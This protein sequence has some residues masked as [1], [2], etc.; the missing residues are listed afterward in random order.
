MPDRERW[1]NYLPDGTGSGLRFA[2]AVQN[3]SQSRL[4]GKIYLPWGMGFHMLW[5][6][7]IQ[8]SGV[9]TYDFKKNYYNILF[10]LVLKILFLG[11]NGV[12]PHQP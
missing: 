10:L 6:Y 8:I 4:R 5:P 3:L 1:Q 2:G 12:Y 9:K 11:L 7:P